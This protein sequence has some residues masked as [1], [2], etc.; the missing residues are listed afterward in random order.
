MNQYLFQSLVLSTFTQVQ[1]VNSYATSDHTHARV[2][3]LSPSWVHSLQ[4]EKPRGF[5][6]FVVFFF[7]FFAAPLKSFVLQRFLL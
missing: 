5:S 7:V 4:K 1:N 6:S 3:G 2:P